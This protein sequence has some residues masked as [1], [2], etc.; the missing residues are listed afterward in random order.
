VAPVSVGVPSD[1]NRATERHQWVIVP[2]LSLLGAVGVAGGVARDHPVLVGLWTAYL[3][4]AA[5]F[6]YGV[7]R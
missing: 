3:L 6:A 5:V 4:L 2:G 7:I 1:A